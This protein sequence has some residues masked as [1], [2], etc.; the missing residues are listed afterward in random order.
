M[1]KLLAIL[2]FSLLWCN[3]SYSN[4]YSSIGLF[5]K[6]IDFNFECVE[7]DDPNFTFDFGLKKIKNTLYFLRK[8]TNT[9]KYRSPAS[10]VWDFGEFEYEGK[11]Y[12]NMKMFFYH[13]PNKMSDG[14]YIL[15]RYALLEQNRKYDLSITE[16]EI[17]QELFD[18]LSYNMKTRVEFIKEKNFDEAIKYVIE[19]T[20]LIGGF[21]M[22]NAK[23]AI[24]DWSWF[25]N[26]KEIK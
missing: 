9:N 15:S 19:Y 21:L 17:N 7:R 3:I 13:Y 10:T 14:R 25:F 23:T 22:L 26:C 18:K 16:F 20:D 5:E 4:E 11:Q 6:K 2:V 1:K 12:S 8:N 24:M